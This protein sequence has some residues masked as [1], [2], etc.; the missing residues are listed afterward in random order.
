MTDVSR[1][2]EQLVAKTYKKLADRNQI[3]PV[4][5]E[6]GI[7][8]GDVLIVSRGCIKDLYKNNELIYRDISLNEAAI[9]IANLMAHRKYHQLCDRI[10]SADQDYGRW[11]SE[12]Q[13]LKEQHI[14]AKIASDYDRADILYARYQEVKQR[15]ETAKKSVLVLINS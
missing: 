10:Y 1:R 3:L 8:V 6:Q 12:W 11:F 5:T 4:K 7:L 13:I 2:F 15:A 14:R 9:R